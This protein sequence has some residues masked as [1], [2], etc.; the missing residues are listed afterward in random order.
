MQK[1]AVQ[2]RQARTRER[3]SFAEE[4]L[5]HIAIEKGAAK[6]KS[7]CYKNDTLGICVKSRKGKRSASGLHLRKT[8]PSFDSN[9]GWRHCNRTIARGL[10][11]AICATALATWSRKEN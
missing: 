2:L 6:N 5:M 8:L 1:L 3:R 11:D 10:V 9:R 7:F 4:S